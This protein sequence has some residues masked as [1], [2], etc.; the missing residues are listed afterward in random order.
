MTLDT[1]PKVHSARAWANGKVC[2]EC[3]SP[4]WGD[5]GFCREHYYQKLRDG[6]TDIQKIKMVLSEW[7]ELDD[8]VRMRTA[9]NEG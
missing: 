8:G 7:V 1:E 3:G 5:A 6:A 2:G 4:V 9:T